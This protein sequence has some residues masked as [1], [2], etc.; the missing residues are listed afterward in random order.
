M[1]KNIVMKSKILFFNLVLILFCCNSLNYSNN[2]RFSHNYLENIPI[3]F[4]TNPYSLD[5]V[6]IFLPMNIQ[7][8]YPNEINASFFKYKQGNNFLSNDKVDFFDSETHKYFPVIE[9]RDIDLK[10]KKLD[11][12]LHKKINISL[13][14]L[15]KILNKMNIAP[16]QKGFRDTVFVGNI[17]SFKTKNSVFFDEQNKKIDTLFIYYTEKDDRKFK[18][19]KFKIDW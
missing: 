6:N 13:K 12:I 18:L 4:L 1:L 2:L 9:I 16:K 11:L 15:N 10:N 17:K 5:S 3:Y 7:I 14:E 19:E 8:K